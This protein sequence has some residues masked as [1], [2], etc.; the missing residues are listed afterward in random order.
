MA[1]R[2][3]SR[4]GCRQRRCRDCRPGMRLDPRPQFSCVRPVFQSGHMGVAL[5]AWGRFIDGAGN[6][7]TVPALPT[8]PGAPWLLDF[9]A[10]EV[11]ALSAA[12]FSAVQLPPVSKVQ[13]GAGD[14][15][16]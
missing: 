12:G 7:I 1:Q 15:C 14:G 10:L 5:I 6:R 3:C 8:T 4:S 2:L 11:E 9:L 13:G 16:D